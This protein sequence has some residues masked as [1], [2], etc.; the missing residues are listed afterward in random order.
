LNGATIIENAT[1][2]AEDADAMDLSKKI[3]SKE[4]TVEVE[5][6]E[7]YEEEQEDLT[8]S[9]YDYNMPTYESKFRV[10]W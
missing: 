3:F 4:S 1:V 10:T 6:E 5:L 7:E 2:Q 9:V 8:T